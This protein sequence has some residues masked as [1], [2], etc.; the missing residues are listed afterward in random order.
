[1]PI[2]TKTTI[3]SILVPLLWSAL[4]ATCWINA[5]FLLVLL[6]VERI[7]ELFDL[8]GINFC[9]GLLPVL[10]GS[11]PPS[12]DW[13]LSL[14]SADSPDKLWGVYVLVLRKPGHRHK[15][16]IGSATGAA[17]GLRSRLEDYDKGKHLARYIK[18][19]FK[20]GYTIQRKVLLATCPIPP[21]SKIPVYRVFLLAVE[22]IFPCYFWTMSKRDFDYGYNHICPWPLHSFTHDGAC[23]HNV[24]KEGFEGELDLTEEQLQQIADDVK[25]KNIAYGRAYHKQQRVDATPEFKAAQ[26]RA[27]K[28][29]RPRTEMLR[30]QAVANKSFYCHLCHYPAADNGRLKVHKESQKHQRRVLENSMQKDSDN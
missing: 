2:T 20:D 18:T 24:L 4:H 15:V 29:A 22:A 25:A 19:A 30:R 14:P 27:N 26:A 9:S 5:R 17:R 11:R 13:F 1:M 21:A 28:K 6:S 7:S 16:Y 8:V 12:V 10:Q 23:S 3:T